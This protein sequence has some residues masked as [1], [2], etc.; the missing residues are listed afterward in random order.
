M[1]DIHLKRKQRGLELKELR[2]QSGLS[3]TQLAK[4][5]GLGQNTISQIESAKI[6]WSVNVEIIYVETINEYNLSKIKQ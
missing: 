2:C 4:I 1:I 6:G 5:S 3:Q